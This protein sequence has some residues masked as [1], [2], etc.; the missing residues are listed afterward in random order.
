[1]RLPDL[2]PY[3]ASVCDATYWGNAWP[4]A[5]AGGGYAG[6]MY[7]APNL[8]ILALPALSAFVQPASIAQVA[9]TSAALTP[10]S[11]DRRR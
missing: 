10:P 2:N 1:M 8:A 4:S 9:G 3:F 11:P 7:S 5:T 6:Q